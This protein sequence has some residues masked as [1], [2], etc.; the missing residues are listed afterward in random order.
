MPWLDAR[1]ARGRDLDYKSNDRGRELPRPG[2]GRPVRGDRPE[3]HQRPRPGGRRA[4][5]HRPRGRRGRART[6]EQRLDRRLPAALHRDRQRL[7]AAG[8]A[9]LARPRDAVVRRRPGALPARLVPHRPAL[10]TVHLR[11]TAP[12]STR[13][14]L[15]ALREQVEKRYTNK[16]VY[17][18]GNAWQQ[19][20]DQVD[21]WR[22]T[23]LRSQTLVLRR[24]RRAARPRRR[25][26]GRRHH[27]R[28]AALRGGRRARLAHPAGGPLRRRRSRPSS[29]CCRAT[30][31]SA[32]RR[33]FRTRTLKHSADAQDRARRRPADQ[34]HRLPQQ[35]P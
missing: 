29:A 8:R 6:P 17:E 14:P 22:S 18:L 5:R 2:R 20:V 35:D 23:A 25:Q 30:P 33:C 26:E 31:S 15:E 11:R 28:R 21:K 10:P 24:L 19:Q 1:Q 27:L 12:P 13:S 9:G 16:F 7:G 34:R 32:W 4:D 3:D